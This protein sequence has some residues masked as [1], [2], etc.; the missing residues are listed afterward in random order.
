MIENRDSF[1]LAAD[2]YLKFRPRYPRELYAYLHGL[3]VADDA[4]LDCAT[5]NGQAA[6][7]LADFF[8]R[9]AAFDSSERQIAAAIADPRVEYR[10]GT[11][12]RLPFD[13]PFDLIAAA[14]GAHWFDLPA[15]YA[16]VERVAR[17]NAV[18]AIWGYSYCRV[19]DAIDA[20]VRD[21]L[22]DRIEPYWADGNR[23]IQDK[24]ETIPFPFREIAAPPFVM[25]HDWTRAGYLAYLGTWSAVARFADEHGSDP[26]APLAAALEPVWPAAEVR[27]VLFDLVMRIGRL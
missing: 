21:V 27:P 13:G 3:C 20:V 17:E 11:A 12:E 25:R 14:Q 2:A 26:V 24:Y 5:G 1:G 16:E 10:V 22:L 4:A 15:F 18:V 7:A 23:V 19:G 9:V 6:V 8:G